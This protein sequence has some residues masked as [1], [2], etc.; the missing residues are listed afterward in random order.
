MADKQYALDLID[1][2][3]AGEVIRQRS[4][5]GYINATAM[6]RVSGKLWAEYR[7]RPS[8]QEFLAELELGM[9]ISHTQLIVTTL[10]TPG[11]DAR[12]QGTWVH[13]YV[14]I[15]LAQWLSAKFAV[16]VSQWV[17]AWMSGRPSAE[18]GWQQFQDR[19]SLT[20]DAVPAGYFGI[21]RESADVY[22]AL[23][24]GGVG[25]GARLLLDISVGQHWGRHW[26]VA[27]LEQRF[28]PPGRYD[29]NYPSYF[30]QAL[31]NPQ[32][33]HCYPDSSLGEF[34]R[35]M[36]ED[37]LERHLPDYLK[38]QIKMGKV[39]ND[40]AASAISVLVARE[41]GRARLK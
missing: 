26:R 20:F 5:D 13:P 3:H 24:K 28:G 12:N 35:W 29:H 34:R 23:V 37:Y 22:G 21:F 30:P 7:R 1:H 2:V 8:T 14:A 33:A 19:I 32:T 41:R 38:A 9:G 11:G 10:G 39:A 25:L 4:R 15:H 36:R 16:R 17:F 31:S 6:C 27:E 18:V 40:D